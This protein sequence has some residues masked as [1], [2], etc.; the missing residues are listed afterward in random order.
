M[1]IR[2]MTAEQLET[3]KTEIAGLIDND[4]ADLDALESEVRAI[5]TE[6]EAR[7]ATETKRAE[8]RA[9]VSAGAGVV[10]KSFEKKG[11]NNMEKRN[12]TAESAEYRSGFLKELL[13]KELTAEERSAV[14]FV[15][16]TTDSTY[17][18]GAVLPR[19][20][21]DR[22][23]DNITEKH[24]IMGDITMYRTGT[25]L[26][27]AK[28]TA[29]TQGDA[30]VVAEGAANDDEINTFVKVTLSGKDFSKHIDI[31][32]AMAKMS[33]DAFED[34][35]VNEISDR[36]GNAMANDVITQILTDYDSENNAVTVESASGAYADF[37][38]AFSRLHG[39]T[40]SVVYASQSTIY[41]FIFGL[42]DNNN[43]PIFQP[44]NDGDV[45][46]YLLGAPVKVE[47]AVTGTRLLIGD[48][49]AVVY[50][51]VQDIMVENDRDIKKHVIT[52]S[53]YARGEGALLNP[54]AFATLTLDE[55]P[56]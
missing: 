33:L 36:L 30:A 24:C 1:E 10:L 15:M 11:E 27:V 25:I 8:I 5:N 52:Y 26:E 40:K 47:D 18:S 22:I 37:A 35:L 38:D 55:N 49:S 4:G 12:Y 17:G 48:P 46:G 45:E 51:M 50:N 56:L 14:D 9:A 28:R 39:A 21:I 3:R 29:I 7:K 19:T 42:C 23:W 20:M 43:R 41:K 6:L 16:T 53:G 31:S 32:Y 54:K 44:S 13:G 2:E 34:Y